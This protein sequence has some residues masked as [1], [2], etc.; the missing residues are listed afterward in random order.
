M[1]GWERLFTIAPGIGDQLRV[2]GGG[3]LVDHLDRSI[4]RKRPPAPETPPLRAT[5]TILTGG[6]GAPNQ[7]SKAGRRTLLGQ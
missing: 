5:Q 4:R 2:K 3:D 1:M 7:G 6:L